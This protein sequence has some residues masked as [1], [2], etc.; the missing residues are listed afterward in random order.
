[1]VLGGG[2]FGRWLD[3][4]G[5]A[6]MNGISD[7][8]RGWRDQ[9]SPLLLCENIAKAQLPV[10]R[11]LTLTRHWISSTLILYFPT[12]RTGKNK[13]LLFISHVVYGV[14]LQQSEWAKTSGNS[15]KWKKN[16]ISEGYR[17]YDS[18]Y[19]ILLKW[20]ITEIENRFVVVRGGK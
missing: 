3:C 9:N 2:A 5:G 16:L 15:T 20:H 12:S 13:V 10:K 1:M 6:I 8:L 4:E 14:L 11:K 18:I 17:L 7:L 19:I